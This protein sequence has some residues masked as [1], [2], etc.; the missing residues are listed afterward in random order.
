MPAHRLRRYGGHLGKACCVEDSRS[1]GLHRDA[2]PFGPAGSVR[3][4]PCRDQESRPVSR[5]SS[6]SR[7]SSAVAR[8]VVSSSRRF[9]RLAGLP[10]HESRE[11]S[12]H[13]D[14]NRGPAVYELVP[15]KRCGVSVKPRA[16]VAQLAGLRFWPFQRLLRYAIDSAILLLRDHLRA[17]RRAI[18]TSVRSTSM[19]SHH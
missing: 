15:P 16:S 4:C 10:T 14:L 1:S 11:W 2:H 5:A 13:S 18:D 9:V 7:P 19:S 8:P 3:G 6:V 12:R 17:W